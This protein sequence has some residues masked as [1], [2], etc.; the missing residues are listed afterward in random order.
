[1][2]EH[3]FC[4]IGQTR[5]IAPADRKLYALRDVTAT[6]ESIPLIAASILSKKLAEGIDALVLDVK[7]GRGA[8][9]KTP[10]DARVLATALRAI[11]GRA[12]KKVVAVLTSM[13]EPLGLAVGNALEVAEALEVLRGGGP[14]DLREV[15]LELGARMLV[16]GEK[17]RTLAE[18]HR[19]LEAV[20]RSGEALDRMRRVVAAQGG[21]PRAVDDPSLLPAAK[22]RLEVT[23]PSS[24]W[25]SS[26]DAEEIG[27]AAMALGAGRD[28]ADATIDPAVGVMLARKVGDPVKKGHPLATI[29]HNDPTRGQQAATRLAAAYTISRQHPPH[30]SK[31]LEVI[32]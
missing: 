29:H 26:I 4:L 14:P 8:F 10:E 28:R 19:K 6:V 21:N 27:L 22:H 25:V 17:A 18:A 16:L 2:R 32:P 20:I 24:G 3:G 30:R 11:G 12:G 15:T 13:D 31:I 1:V 7:V 5:E 9:M 23:S